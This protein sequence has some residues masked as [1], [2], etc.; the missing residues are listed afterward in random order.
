MSEKQT[1]RITNPQPTPDDIAG[2]VSNEKLRPEYLKDFLGQEKTKEKVDIFITAAKKRNAAADH[3]LFC[4]PPGLGKTTLARIVAG[5]L[6]SKLHQTSG[7][8]LERT[9]DLAAILTGLE[10]KDVLFIDEIHRTNRIVEEYLYSAM[11]DFSIDLLVGEGPSARSMKINLEK[12]TLIGATTRTGLITSPLYSRF[13]MELR[14]EH[15]AQNE[16]EAIVKRS[17]K[18]MKVEITDAAAAHISQRSRGTPRVANRLLRRVRDYVEV[19]ADGKIDE[20]LALECLD[21]LEVDSFGLDG[22]DRAILETVI[23]RFGGGPVGIETIAAS[24]SEDKE[25]IEQVYEPFLLRKGLIEK[26]PKG[27]KAAPL[28]YSH[29][30]LED[31]DKH[32]TLV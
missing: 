1:E 28:A 20:T 32:R 13:G 19:K 6:G 10:E 8:V 14:L 24:V 25:T 9:G 17:A 31:P 3:V 16:I 5:E 12:F 22:M 2:V 23:L 7:P 30:G 29:L 21:M 4:G 26:T 15:Y 27:R 18:I 11:E